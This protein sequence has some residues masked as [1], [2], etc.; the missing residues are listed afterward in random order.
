MA[1]CRSRSCFRHM[2][3]GEPFISFD[4]AQTILPTV[5]AYIAHSHAGSG[6]DLRLACCEALPL[7]QQ[8]SK[9]QTNFPYSLHIALRIC[10]LTLS[11]CSACLPYSTRRLLARYGLPALGGDALSVRPPPALADPYTLILLL[12]DTVFCCVIWHG[13]IPEFKY[14]R[15]CHWMMVNSLLQENQG[16]CQA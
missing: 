6:R 8:F 12:K 7:V 16:P 9:R 11:C 2:W 3:T 5:T 1:Y 10:L 15:L 4:S 14:Y 13:L